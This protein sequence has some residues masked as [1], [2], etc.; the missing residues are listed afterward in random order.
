MNM[1]LLQAAVFVFAVGV[2]VRADMSGCQE[3]GGDFTSTLVPPPACQSP[4]GICTSGLLTGEVEGTYDFVMTELVCGTDPLDPALCTYAGDSIVTTD[5]GTIITKDT[6]VMRQLPPPALTSFVTTAEFVEGT[7][8]YKNATGVFV[9]TGELNFLTGE[10]VGEYSL[11]VCH[12][13]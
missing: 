3:F 6:G 12:A 10:A 1:R 13:R 8:R 11:Q 7:R 9:A 5:K 4:I 2:G